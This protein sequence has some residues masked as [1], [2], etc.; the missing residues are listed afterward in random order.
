MSTMQRLQYHQYG[1]PEM[2][3]LEHFDLGTPGKGELAIRV[4]LA[5]INPIDWSRNGTPAKLHCN[6][7]DCA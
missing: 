1:G 7:S 3:R 2:M 4:H 5:A 6:R